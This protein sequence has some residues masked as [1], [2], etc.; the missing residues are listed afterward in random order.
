MKKILALTLLFLASCNQPNVG[1]D[2]YQFGKK[3]YENSA[4]AVNIVTYK[5]KADL[6]R[7]SRKYGVNNPDLVAFSLLSPIRTDVCEI[8]MMDPSVSYQPEFVGHEFLHCVYGQWHT[9]NASRS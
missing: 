4:V 2:Q 3:Q 7:A 9:N 1:A 5:T 6:L 8:H